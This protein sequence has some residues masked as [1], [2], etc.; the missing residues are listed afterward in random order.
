MVVVGGIYCPNHY[1]SRWLTLLSMGTP[2]SPV[3]HRTQ[4]CSLLSDARHVS[5][6]LGFGVVDVEGFCPF[7]AS[8]SPVRSD[9]VDCLLTSDGQTAVHSI[10]APLSHRTVRWYTGQSDDFLWMTAEKTRE[11]PVR[12]V[13]QLGHQTLSGA[14]LAAASLFCS[15]LVELF[16]GHFLCMFM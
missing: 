7:A 15:K 5:R 14:P 9:I 10:V 8:D 4:H 12:E 11:R 1:S 3:V 13:F 2:D 6:P 16:H